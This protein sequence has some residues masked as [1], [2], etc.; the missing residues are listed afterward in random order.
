MTKLTCLLTIVFVL[1]SFVLAAQLKD[2]YL[3]SSIQF[4]NGR[5]E[6]VLVLNEETEKL[7]YAVSVKDSSF[8]SSKKT[9]S[10]QE[11]L[12]IDFENGKKFRQIR[13]A[14]H[15]S[16]D[17]LTVLGRLLVTG[18]IELYQAY[19]NGA[20]ILVAKKEGEIFPLQDDEFSSNDLEVK[21]NFFRSYLINVLQDAPEAIR[22]K[23]K[24]IKFDNKAISQLLLD[25]NKLYEGPSEIIKQKKENK[26]FWI[27]GV[28]LKT[29]KNHPY[30]IWGFVNYR[31]YITDFSRSTSINTGIHYYNYQFKTSISPTSVVTS[32]RS[33]A[34]IPIFVQQ[35][36]LNKKARPYV[37]A[38][39][40]VSY[41]NTKAG[42]PQFEDTKGF[43]R[44]FGFHILGGAGIEWNVMPNLMLK[45]DYRYENVLHGFMGGLAYIF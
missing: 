34:S 42:S 23:T 33:I 25:Y 3:K 10:A 38:G 6:T 24:K 44:N 18:K 37:F 26:P 9:Y 21:R 40:N 14:K 39:V 7:N 32:T 22:T 30:G 43:Q 13:F 36:L 31:L 45:A 41:V 8:I 4:A 12:S 28:L 5:T 17:T 11:I 16:K 35:N 1:Q 19:L 2:H 29:T 27:A 15:T 20:E